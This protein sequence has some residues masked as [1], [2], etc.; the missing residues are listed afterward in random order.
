MSFKI[1]LKSFQVPTHYRMSLKKEK[2]K[3]YASEAGR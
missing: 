2:Q 1:N 3:F